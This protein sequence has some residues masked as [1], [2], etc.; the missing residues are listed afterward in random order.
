M[1]QSLYIMRV[2]RNTNRFYLCKLQTFVNIE[3]HGMCSYHCPYN[4]FVREETHG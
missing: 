1:K 2:K 3:A 4:G